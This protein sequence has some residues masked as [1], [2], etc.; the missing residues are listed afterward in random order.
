VR[1]QNPSKS[2]AKH[3]PLTTKQKA[4]LTDLA[5][6]LVKLNHA[7][8]LDDIVVTDEDDKLA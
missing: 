1:A 4:L 2:P 5:E 7:G 3:P 6:Y 8:L